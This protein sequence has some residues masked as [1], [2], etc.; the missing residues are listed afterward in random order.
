MLQKTLDNDEFS[1]DARLMRGLA[2]LRGT[3]VLSVLLWLLVVAMV[4]WLHGRRQLED[5]VAELAT[6]TALYRDSA[7]RIANQNFLELSKITA[8]LTVR[9]DVLALS[10]KY[11]AFGR[12]FADLA[13][14]Q[15][16]AQLKDDAQVQSTSARLQEIVGDLR[17]DLIF[18]EDRFGTIIAS[19][20]ANKPDTVLGL[21]F[22]DRPSF[23]E[24]MKNEEGSMFVVGRTSRELGLNF[25]SR[26]GES[27]SEATGAVVAR[28]PVERFVEHLSRKG[29]EFIIID[30]YGMIVAS[31]D[32]GLLLNHV[33]PLSPRRP[34]D[35]RLK[36]YYR[37]DQLKAIDLAPYEGR[38]HDLHWAL[39]G[40][41]ILLSLASLGNKG[42]QLGVFS[43][44]HEKDEIDR[45]YFVIGLLVGFMGIPIGI[46]LYSLFAGQMRRAASGRRLKAVNAQL[47]RA[48][49]E[50]NRYLGI[51]AHDL[52]NPL[53]SLRGLSQLMLEMDLPEEQRLQFVN[54][55]HRTS[56]E[57]LN[58][59]NDLLDVSHIEAGRIE[60]SLSPVD[61]PALIRERLE[62]LTL[63]ASRKQ[64]RIDLITGDMAATP[65]DKRRFGQVIDN[66]A[67]NAI[68]FSPLGSV[69]TVR[70]ADNSDGVEFSVEDEGP[71]IGEVDRE[72]LFK[73]F[74]KLSAKPT[75][76]EKS[77]GLGLSIVKN[78]VEAHGG[79][80]DVEK[81][82]SG[83]AR[84][85][86][87]LPRSLTTA[88]ET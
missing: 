19:S 23:Q 11:S 71:G 82:P 43:S 54:V 67:S 87:L 22:A 49:A 39:N 55:I 57:L 69:V 88:E 36:T 51:A 75:A 17:Y 72:L 14:A 30:S 77:T 3:V 41:P 12:S 20:D 80:I 53:S 60:L 24:A 25:S 38:L 65:L 10:E 70:A 2:R 42:Y 50:K 52:R 37:Q 73:S 5:E 66:L 34:D 59:V 64:I 62:H 58:L 61:L 46:A 45:A 31:G 8:L 35:E 16:I 79:R 1:S 26:I 78:I 7:V 18:V 6:D 85:V 27:Q 44:L 40:K 76:G 15:R 84:F 48:N 68:K 4:A 86:V 56:D 21:N 74:Q 83:G 28:L 33:G 81:A 29:Y 63:Q 13:V 32:P 47:E 9:A